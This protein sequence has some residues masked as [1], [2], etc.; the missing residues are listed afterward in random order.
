MFTQKVVISGDE[1]TKML[2]ENGYLHKGFAEGELKN[3][4]MD[5][6]TANKI[7]LYQHIAFEFEV[8]SLKE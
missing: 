1:L 5:T 2:L 7:C 4:T 8:D 6:V 3:M